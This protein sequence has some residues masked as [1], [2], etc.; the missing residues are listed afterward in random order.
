MTPATC[1]A[2]P[3]RSLCAAR[4]RACSTSATR[5]PCTNPCSHHPRSNKQLAR[6][7]LTACTFVTAFARHVDT[8]CA[9]HIVEWLLLISPNTSMH[10]WR[11]CC[12]DLV[13]L[14]AVGDVLVD[15][16]RFVVSWLLLGR[17]QRF[18]QSGR[19]IPRSL[20][21]AQHQRPRRHRPNCPRLVG[22]SILHIHQQHQTALDD[23]NTLGCVTYDACT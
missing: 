3:S 22:A 12:I 21:A 16:N 10:V 7:L 5:H 18:Q 6:N 14:C 9:A 15:V 8:R 13:L 20:H 23:N 1:Y 4:Q 2:R 17:T 19:T 11:A